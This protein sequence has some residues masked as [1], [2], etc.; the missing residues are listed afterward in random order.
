MLLCA[1][2]VLAEEEDSLKIPDVSIIESSAELLYGLVH[3]RYILTRQ[4]LQAMAA[5][6]FGACPRVFCHATAVVPCGRSD[7]PG[8]DTVK[9]YCPN[10]GDL[11]APPSS[12]FQGVDGAFFGTTFPHLFYQTYRD[13]FPAAFHPTLAAPAAGG[14]SSS[15]SQ[16]QQQQV[17]SPNGG[18]SGSGSGEPFVNPDPHGG[19]KRP[20]AE[21]YQKRIYG[22]KVSERA[23]SGPRMEWLRMRPASGAELDRVDWKGRWIGG[24]GDGGEDG[25]DGEGGDNGKGELFEGAEDS[26]EEDEEEEEEEEDEDDKPAAG[27]GASAP[28][29]T[30]GAPL[31]KL[32]LCRA[33]ALVSDQ[34]LTLLPP[35]RP[36]GLLGSSYPPAKYAY[37]RA[38]ELAQLALQPAPRLTGRRTKPY[39][40][41]ASYSCPPLLSEAERDGTFGPLSAGEFT[42][43]SASGSEVDELPTT[44]GLVTERDEDDDGMHPP[45]F[46]LARKRARDLRLRIAGSSSAVSEAEDPSAAA[47]ALSLALGKAGRQSSTKA[48]PSPTATTTSAADPFGLA[49]A[50]LV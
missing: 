19:L 49:S 24:G 40:A 29:A 7:Q 28:G 9:L 10:C 32:G 45:S 4:G 22:F 30:E 42:S 2:V 33:T 6:S 25:D 27:A 20:F 12:R 14:S 1:H 41:E 31:S 17:A 48:R 3:Q 50:L 26:G 15:S 37:P 16:Q 36:A 13:L 39:P 21:V 34:S 18:A 44:P 43:L 38:L 5:K 23:R 11:Y 47:G 35:S 8:L 46:L